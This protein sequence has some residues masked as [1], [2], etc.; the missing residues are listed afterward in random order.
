[1]LLPAILQVLSLK[2]SK[3]ARENPGHLDLDLA[4]LRFSSLFAF[5]YL[6]LTVVTG[7]FFDGDAGAESDFPGELHV[8]NGAVEAAQAVLQMAFFMELKNKV[9]TVYY[10]RSANFSFLLISLPKVLTTPEEM[11]SLPGRQAAAF[12]FLFNLAQWIVLS[13]EIQ[14]VRF[15]KKTH[16]T[17]PNKIPLLDM[18]NK[19]FF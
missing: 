3:S 17:G 1:M 19:S 13:F 15:Q 8:A 14:K 5:L 2:D 18:C 9:M 16:K 7:A 10:G 4:L 12:L 6:C 11:S